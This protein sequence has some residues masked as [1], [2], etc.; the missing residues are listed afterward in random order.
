MDEIKPK[1]KVKEIIRVTPGKLHAW[2]RIELPDGKETI[3]KKEIKNIP[4]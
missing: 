4:K 2:V 3:I 1:Y